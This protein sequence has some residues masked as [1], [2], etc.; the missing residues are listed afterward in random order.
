M[1]EELTLGLLSTLLSLLRLGEGGVSDLVE[2]DSRH[3]EL[4]RGGDGISAV[5]SSERY[6]VDLVWT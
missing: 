6:T 2:L 3:V 5:D 1:S 4:G